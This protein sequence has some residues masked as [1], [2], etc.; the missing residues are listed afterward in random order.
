MAFPLTPY[1]HTCHSTAVIPFRVV[2]QP[3]IP[4]HEQ[5]AFAARK[6]MFSGQLRPGDPFPS[7]RALS[8][9]TKIHPNTAHKV[10]AQL[11]NEGLLTVRPGIGTLVA[12]PPPSSRAQ[13]SRLLGGDMEQLVVEARRLGL[14]LDDLH[15]AL[16]DHW[17]RL[18]SDKQEET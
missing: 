6:A 14:G 2:A 1:R 7:V 3:G 16:D 15:S 11:I 17:G 5:V 9:A 13:R 18:Q 8:K 12:E 4:V 10:I